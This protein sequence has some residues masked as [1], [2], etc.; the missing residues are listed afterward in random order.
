MIHGV[1]YWYFHGEVV[2]QGLDMFVDKAV[3]VCG[4][5]RVHYMDRRFSI[6]KRDDSETLNWSSV[7]LV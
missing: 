4:I 3:V 2:S 1:E 7:S 5:F 6:V